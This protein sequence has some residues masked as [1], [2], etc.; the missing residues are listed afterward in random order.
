MAKKNLT[1]E[2]IAKWR[3]DKPKNEV[4][5]ATIP[6]GE[7]NLVGMVDNFSGFCAGYIFYN[8]GG[9]NKKQ[10]INELKRAIGTCIGGAGR[11]LV[12]A[13]IINDK[14]FEAVAELI[15]EY[16]GIELTTSPNV[17]NFNTGNEVTVAVLTFY[18]HHQ[19]IFL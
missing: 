7:L 9:C 12:F 10:M 3:K 2:L 8:Y 15:K 13:T 17:Y 5:P 6:T 11:M 4:I 1:L 14:I 18:Q 19:Y 16:N